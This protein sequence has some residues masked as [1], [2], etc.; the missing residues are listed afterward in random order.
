MNDQEVNRI[1]Q[2]V[3]ASTSYDRKIV[4][5]IIRIG[6]SEMTELAMTTTRGFE[7]NTLLE[8]VC[9]WTIMRTGQA[10]HVVR[11]VMGCAGRWLDECFEQLAE[12][13]A[14]R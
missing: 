12:P 1:V 2:Y 9:R 4:E 14:E 10:E 5:D 8:Y 13:P 11:E 7:R 6:F 3:T